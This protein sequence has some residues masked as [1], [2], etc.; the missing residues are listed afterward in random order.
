MS[1]ATKP[2]AVN[3]PPWLAAVLCGSGLVGV[4][5]CTNPPPVPF[6]PQATVCGLKFDTKGKPFGCARPGEPC[7]DAK[8]FQSSCGPTASDVNSCYCPPAGQITV[9]PLP[10]DET[11][12][13]N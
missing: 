6:P 3:I 13:V 9:E 8:G 12:R 7:T 5:G 4:T 11:S 10:V 2:D 1:E